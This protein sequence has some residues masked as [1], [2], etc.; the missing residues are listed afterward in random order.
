VSIAVSFP[1]ADPRFEKGVRFG[2][3]MVIVEHEPIM[4]VWGFAPS[5]VGRAP[6][7]E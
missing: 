5:G 7:R 2:E 6:G 4:E 1:G 3:N